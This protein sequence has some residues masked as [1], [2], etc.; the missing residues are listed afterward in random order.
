MNISPRLSL[1]YVS[2]SQSQK[3]VT[4]NDGLRRLDA[5]LHL[6][7]LSASLAAEPAA[8]AEGDAYI[9]PAGASGAQWSAFAAGDV[10]A[11]QDGAWRAAAPKPGWRAYVADAD[12]FIYFDGAAWTNELQ[13][14]GDARFGRLGVNADADSVNRF[15]LKS[16]AA[17]LSHD[18]VTPGTGD[19]RQIVNKSAAARTASVLFQSEFSGRAEFGL[20]GDDDFHL[21]VSAD[22]AAWKDAIV[23]VASSGYVGIG[24]ASPSR[25]LTVSSAGNL[26]PAGTASILVEGSANKERVEIRSAGSNPQPTFQGKGFGGTPA[27]PTP[28][29][30]GV[31]LFGLVGAGADSN[32]LFDPGAALIEMAAAEN[33]TPTGHGSR[34]TFGTTP[35]GSTARGIDLRIEP[36]G[37][38]ATGDYAPACELDV[39]GPVRVKSYAKASLPAA[40]AGAGQ[41][42]YVSDEAGGAVIAFSDGTNWRRVS[43]RAVVS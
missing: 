34:I 23:V 28:T 11:F 13:L 36:G 6:R 26:G 41:M 12:G 7:A 5:L 31:R 8:P 4:V 17:L 33:F 1:P 40:S 39:D 30:N 38:M 29:L 25:P 42:I 32:G 14:G 24:E 19:A 2:A 37:K 18:D 21:K 27:S 9:I 15:A 35:L 10:A 43:D 20:A 22:G 3:H 16:D